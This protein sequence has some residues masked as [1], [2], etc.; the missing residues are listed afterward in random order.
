[1]GIQ[2]RRKY[3]SDFKRNAV[4]LS[5]EPGR[6]IPEVAESLGI[7]KDLIYQWRKALKEKGELAFPGKGIEALTEEQKRIRELE[8]KLKDTEMERDILKKA[9]AIFSKA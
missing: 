9:M 2:K 7:S 3:D 8:K 4:L 5:Q 1:M 6:S